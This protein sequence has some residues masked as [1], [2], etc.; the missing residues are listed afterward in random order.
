[1]DRNKKQHSND[2]I[3]K[4]FFSSELLLEQ[5]IYIHVITGLETYLSSPL[6]NSPLSGD[7]Y[8]NELLASHYDKWIKEVLWINILF[9][10]SLIA[11][12]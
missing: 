6:R 9:S 1:M 7:E 11:W 10:K 2:Y 5:V 8:V 12:L 3:N 4:E